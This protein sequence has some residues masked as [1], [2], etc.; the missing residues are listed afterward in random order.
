MSA[1]VQK[2]TGL[3]FDLQKLFPENDDDRELVVTIPRPA[4]ACYE[5]M[6]DVSRLTEWLPVIRSVRVLARDQ[7]DRPLEAAFTAQ[8][9]RA[10]VGYRLKY[11]FSDR[12]LSMRWSTVPGSMFQVSGS[13][14]FTPL[15]DKAALMR[16]QIDTDFS[17]IGVGFEE[18]RFDVQQASSVI[19]EFRDF[20]QRHI[21]TWPEGSGPQRRPTQAQVD[22]DA[23]TDEIK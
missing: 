2:Q 14:S 10:T 15:G 9:D 4:R 23:D 16:Y 6:A 1:S 19:A 11:T 8:M 3:P 12:A 5:L 22:E 7:H 18:Q 21:M 20:A 13:V 17:S